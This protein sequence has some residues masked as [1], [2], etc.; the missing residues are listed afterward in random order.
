MQCNQLPALRV[1]PSRSATSQRGEGNGTNHGR[2][3]AGNVS[4]HSSHVLRIFCAQEAIHGQ[5]DGWQSLVET[6]KKFLGY[7]DVP[8][9]A[10]RTLPFAAALAPR[11]MQ[12]RCLEDASNCL[13]PHLLTLTFLE[14]KL[15]SHKLWETFIDTSIAA[16][17]AGSPSAWD[18]EWLR[19]LHLFVVAT[20]AERAASVA[21]ISAGPMV[22]RCSLA[23]RQ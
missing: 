22:L 12:P 19:D 5:P 2:A 18:A 11:H 7:S 6:D 21:K 4:L 3:G 1:V 9:T 20:D 15:Y 17:L 13:D 23:S 10:S 14:T 8:L 16:L